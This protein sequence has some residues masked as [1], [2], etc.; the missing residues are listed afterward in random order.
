[1]TGKTLTIGMSALDTLALKA[2]NVPARSYKGWTV[3]SSNKAV[4]AAIDASGNISVSLVSG[5]AIKANTVVTITVKA[6][7]GSNKT[8]NVKLKLT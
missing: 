5:A 2:E 3:T 7:D 4:I 6:A 1:M 8:A